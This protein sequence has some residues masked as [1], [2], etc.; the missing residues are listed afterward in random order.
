M[1]L[2]NLD[3]DKL[4][5][6]VERFPGGRV[7]VVGDIM[8]D[9]YIWGKVSRISPEAPVPVVNVTRENLLLGGA[10]NVVN[11]ITSLGGHALIAG[12]IG[13]DEPGRS[14]VHHLRENNVITDGLIVEEKR[15]TTIKTRIIAHSQQVVRFDREVKDDISEDT[16]D[17]LLGYIRDHL[18]KGVNAII[19]SDYCKGVVTRRLVAEVVAMA[20][21]KGIMVAVDPKVPHFDYYQNVDILTPNTD[22]ASAGAR[23]EITDD[24]SVLTAGKAI[25]EKLK[26]RSLLITRGEHGMSLFEGDGKVTSIPTVAQEVY[27]VTG[28]GDTVISVLALASAVGASLLDAAILSNFAA[29]IVVGEVGT[30]V[31]TPQQL[32]ER[33]RHI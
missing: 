13:H 20:R 15:P 10:A 25:M 18:D 31:V 29:G 9:H 8:L 4:C 19:L 21:E 12:V 28:A 24:S 23:V 22:E 16:Q 5:S 27:D 33:I 11:N 2:A 32:V 1:P 26:S 6:L 3:R 7:L 30:A 14:I 17:I